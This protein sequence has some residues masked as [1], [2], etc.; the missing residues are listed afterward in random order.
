MRNIYDNATFAI[1]NDR[2]QQTDFNQK[3][4]T[5]LSV[6]VWQKWYYSN[7]IKV[8][9]FKIADFRTQSWQKFE[10]KETNHSNQ[11]KYLLL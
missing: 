7:N 1:T 10:T 6:Q 8:Q 4:S 3:S 2:R 11:M 5:E 9:L